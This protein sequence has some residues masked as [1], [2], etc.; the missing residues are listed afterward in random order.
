MEMQ[1]SLRLDVNMAPALTNQINVVVLHTLRVCFQDEYSFSEDLQ[2]DTLKAGHAL[3]NQGLTHAD[4]L[5][6][7][8]QRRS[9]EK[10]KVWH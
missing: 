9:G 7:M 4:L 2:R 6:K 1:L 3:L 8:I 5:R 10:K